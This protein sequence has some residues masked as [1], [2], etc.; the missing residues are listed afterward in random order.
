MKIAPKLAANVDVV[1]PLIVPYMDGVAEFH[2]RSYNEED[3]AAWRRVVDVYDLKEVV[4]HAPFHQHNLEDV[5]LSP[6][7]LPIVEDYILRQCAFADLAG[8]DIHVLFHISMNVESA[9]NLGVYP[10]ITRLLRH[11]EHSPRVTLLVENTIVGL[12]LGK[13]RVEEDPITAVLLNTPADKVGMCFDL[14]HYLA[15]KNAVHD[16][17]AF[18]PSWLDRIYSIH[19]SETREN[20]GYYQFAATHGCPHRSQLGVARDLCVLRDLGIDLNRVHIVAEITEKDYATRG[21]EAKELAWLHA[22]N[23][24]G[25]VF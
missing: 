5:C 6:T 17:Y 8:L 20:C 16:E 15:S 4:L 7:L 12:D 19:F 22:L 25:I 21:E 23:K 10:A 2:L 3:D 1:P 14:C 18:S 24:E 9:I 11:L 13:K